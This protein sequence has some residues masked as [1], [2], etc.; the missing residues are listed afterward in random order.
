MTVTGDAPRRRDQ[1]IGANIAQ[2]ELTALPILNRNWTMAVGLT[3]GV[4]VSQS[5]TASFACD[6]SS[7]AAAATGAATSRWT[8]SATTT[9]T[10][11]ARAAAR[12]ARPSN[13]CR[14]SRSSPT[15]TTP[16]SAGAPARSST[17]SPNRARNAI[18]GAVFDSYT[19]DKVTSKDFFVKQRNLTK[20]KSSQHDLGGTLGGPIKKDRMH[21]F[22][23]LDR[24]VYRKGAATP[25]PRVRSST[26]RT[27]RA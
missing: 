15:S 5:S 21:F 27:R 26:T 8:A 4:Q 14:S 24:I 3:P 11:A 18:H 7:S 13:R 1:R 25:S 10:S 12:C 22:Y 17:R 16:S 6:R 9:T 2:D 23:S 20:P 19:N